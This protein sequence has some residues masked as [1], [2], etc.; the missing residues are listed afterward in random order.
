ALTT[1]SADN[2]VS[3]RYACTQE[4]ELYFA[5]KLAEHHLQGLLA[6]TDLERANKD[7][8]AADRLQPGGF[9]Y[10]D[11]ADRVGQ[12]NA[13]AAQIQPPIAA[14][15]QPQRSCRRVLA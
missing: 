1:D 6:G 7:S 10:L 14:P 13:V 4:V 8:L 3:R 11:V 9:E 5:G 12:H 15:V 2:T